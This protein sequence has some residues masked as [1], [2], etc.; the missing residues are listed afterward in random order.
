MLCLR[1]IVVC[2]LLF[3]CAL[4][5]VCAQTL[6]VAHCV[7]KTK[8]RLGKIIRNSLQKRIRQRGHA[9]FTLKDYLAAAT[10]RG[11]VTKAYKPKS[12]STLA[13]ALGLSGVVT[14]RIRRAKKKHRVLLRF[15]NEQ[16][17]I[18]VKK[19]F[20]NKN[21]RVVKR[22]ILG[23]VS[24]LTEKMSMLSDQEHVAEDDLESSDIE[25]EQAVAEAAESNQGSPTFSQDKL[26][27]PYDDKLAEGPESSPQANDEASQ[28]STMVAANEETVLSDEVGEDGNETEDLGTSSNSATQETD[29]TDRFKSDD[30]VSQDNEEVVVKSDSKSDAEHDRDEVGSVP[31]I[32]LVG[33]VSVNLRQGLNPQITS[34]YFPAIHLEGTFFLGAYTDTIL[35]KDVGVSALYEHGLGLNYQSM[36]S[37]TDVN[38]Q[39]QHLR[40]EV[41][42]RLS[43]ASVLMSPSFQFR[44]GYAG[45]HHT[46]KDDSTNSRSVYYRYLAGM[47]QCNLWIAR[48]W[49]GISIGGGYLPT[50]EMTDRLSGSG[51]GFM[52]TGGLFVLL[53]RVIHISV[54]YEHLDFSLD[55]ISLGKTS[56]RYQTLVVRFGL[57]YH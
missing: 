40:F 51:T 57:G 19:V 21:L 54:G 8:T 10:E 18:R 13:S 31:N 14:C 16:G 35:I 23:F 7:D 27:N 29:Q 24:S 47:L 49:F 32:L 30:S 38:A 11:L 43:F 28:A 12:I 36:S 53:H 3:S 52:L 26:A 6:V 15:Y 9:L 44:V 37:Q 55:E 39:Q 41:I 5:K 56:D 1:H 4:P 25:P 33:G 46:I 22:A 50:I 20:L 45:L 2:L 17:E 42:Y 48:P 34:N